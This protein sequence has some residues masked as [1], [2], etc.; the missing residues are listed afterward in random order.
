MQ[1]IFVVAKNQKNDGILAL[2]KNGSLIGGLIDEH[3]LLPFLMANFKHLPNLVEL[4]FE[5]ASKYKM[6]LQI[7]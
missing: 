6:N 5:L 1:P 3:S 4:V 7:V 2:S